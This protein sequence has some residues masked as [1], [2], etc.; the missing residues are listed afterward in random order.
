[1][2]IFFPT[3]LFLHTG[4]GNEPPVRY[5]LAAHGLHLRVAIDCDRVACLQECEVVGVFGVLADFEDRGGEVGIIY[6][7]SV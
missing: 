3:D 6:A 1:M 2:L 7:R 5:I 4:T